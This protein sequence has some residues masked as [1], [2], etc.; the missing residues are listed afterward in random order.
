MKYLGR[1]LYMVF[2]LGLWLA[3]LGLALEGWARWRW[4]Y[5]EKNNPFLLSRFEGKLW[6]IPRDESDL[7]SEFLQDEE[8]REAFR[9]P[10]KSAELLA[11]ASAEEDMR[12][13]Y[14][15]FLRLNADERRMFA[16]LYALQLCAITEN[17]RVVDSFL[18]GEP[19]QGGSLSAIIPAEDAQ[20]LLKAFNAVAEEKDI[21]FFQ[22]SRGDSVGPFD[23]CLF[24]DLPET[25][26]RADTLLWMACP[27][28]KVWE[29]M[30][31]DSIWEIP[32]FAGKKHMDLKFIPNAFVMAQ[33]FRMNNHGF[34]DYDVILPKPEGCYRILCIGASTTEEG[35]LNDLTY[36]AILETL[37]NRHFGEKKIDVINC[38]LSG[39]NSN[40][41]KIRIADYLALEPDLMLFYNAVND[42]CH[43]LLPMWVQWS[44]PIDRTLWRSQFIIRYLGNLIIPSDEDIA[45]DIDHYNMENFRF[46]HDCAREKGV[47]LAMCSFAAP[48]V[49]QLSRDERDYYEQITRTSWGGRY[50]S[51]AVYLK[52]LQQY[53]RAIKAFCEDSDILYIPVAENLIG[54]ANFFGD[55]CHLRNPGVELK[56]N[57]I[58]ESLQPFLEQE[59][60]GAVSNP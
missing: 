60:Q 5:I 7:F 44:G 55:I 12:Q 17:G 28:N 29:D 42:I 52:I 9:G 51:F 19:D 45:E 4:N 38:G 21:R 34:R 35:P 8:Q 10:G 30:P 25:D 6:P 46:I 36:P 56:A 3:M 41:H 2:I 11:P 57:I 13:R 26:S 18:D 53:N 33:H 22:R 24:P 23:Y 59:L 40:K 54:T 14:P 31:E 37:L 15:L 39:M 58:F 16:D 48:D 49:T 20:T 1:F 27:R 43:H 47:A 50:V 32:Y